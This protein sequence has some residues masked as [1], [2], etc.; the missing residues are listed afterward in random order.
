MIYKKSLRIIK[1]SRPILIDDLCLEIN[2][3]YSKKFNCKSYD[4]KLIVKMNSLLSDFPF[5]LPLVGTELIHARSEYLDSPKQEIKFTIELNSLAQFSIYGGILLLSTICI[6]LIFSNEANIGIFLAVII[7]LNIAWSEF[8]YRRGK[9]V[10]LRNWDE[11]FG[12]G[13]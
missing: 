7:V 9:R 11:N 12:Y 4:N 6:L 13:F 5:N 10:F 1:S 8:I 3:A 2:S